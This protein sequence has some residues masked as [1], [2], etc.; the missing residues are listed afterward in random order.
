MGTSSCASI[1]NCHK[2][3]TDEEF[4]TLTPQSRKFSLRRL[5]KSRKLHLADRLR[6]PRLELSKSSYIIEEWLGAG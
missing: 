2:L 4:F 6:H 5:T 3:I 1:L